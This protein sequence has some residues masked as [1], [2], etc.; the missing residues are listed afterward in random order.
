MKRVFLSDSSYD[1]AF[2]ALYL[3]LVTTRRGVQRSYFYPGHHTGIIKWCTIRPH[4]HLGVHAMR[5]NKFVFLKP[6]L[7]G[8]R[9]TLM[10]FPLVTDAFCRRNLWFL[11]LEDYRE[12]LSSVPIDRLTQMRFV[13]S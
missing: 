11:F 13:F 1:A 9:V 10:Q 8:E 4:P 6:V 12:N 7:L 3:W 2:V 5:C